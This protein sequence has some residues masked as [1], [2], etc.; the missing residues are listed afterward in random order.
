MR[1]MWY[2]RYLVFN[3]VLQVITW[4]V[5]QDKIAVMRTKVCVCACVRACVCVCAC[6]AG[7]PC[8]SEKDIR[9][10]VYRPC[11]TFRCTAQH[12]PCVA[13]GSDASVLPANAT[14]HTKR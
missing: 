6:L 14:W 5:E 9:G 11:G 12:L 10:Q 4:F 3:V 2:S 1:I 13:G 8:S 7:W